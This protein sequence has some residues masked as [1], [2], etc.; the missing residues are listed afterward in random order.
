MLP[1]WTDGEEFDILTEA[2]ILVVEE[3]TKQESKKPTTA[4]SK[5]SHKHLYLDVL[6]N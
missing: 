2:S 6:Q 5:R 3:L 1:I 4:G